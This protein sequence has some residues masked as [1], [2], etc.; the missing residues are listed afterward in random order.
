MCREDGRLQ[1]AVDGRL[2]RMEKVAIVRNLLRLRYRV[3][4]THSLAKQEVT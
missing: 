4:P 2:L 3:S 1:N